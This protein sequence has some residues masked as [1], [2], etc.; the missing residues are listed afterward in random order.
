MRKVTARA[1]GHSSPYQVASG[2]PSLL[3]SFFWLP[4]ARV[5]VPGGS[6]FSQLQRCGKDKFTFVKQTKTFTIIGQNNERIKTNKFENKL[7]LGRVRQRR[8]FHSGVASSMVH[9]IKE[10]WRREA[11]GFEIPVTRGAFD[12]EKGAPM[13]ESITK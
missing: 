3:N 6:P 10:D 4:A 13:T 5:R 1:A 11:I 12:H 2:I 9:R 8:E 7:I